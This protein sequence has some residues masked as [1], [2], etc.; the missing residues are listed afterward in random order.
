MRHRRHDGFDQ[1]AGVDSNRLEFAP[2][3][4]GE[5]EN[6]SDQPVHLGDRGF[7]EAQGFR[8]ILR[9]LFVCALEYGSTSPAMTGTSGAEAAARPSAAMRLKISVRRSSSSLVKPMMLTSGERK[10]WLTI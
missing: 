8:E 3:L 2:P 1:F 7:D 9:E 4:A 5:V 6:R 10:S